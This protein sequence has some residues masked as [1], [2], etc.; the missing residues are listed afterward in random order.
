MRNKASHDITCPYCN[1]S[2]SLNFRTKD[3]NRKMSKEL[4]NYYC[5]SSCALIFLSPLPSDLKQYYSKEYY[6]VPGTLEELANASTEEK[7]KVEIIQQFVSKGRLLEVGPATGGFAYHAK[8]AGYEVE[9]IEMD[10]DC[11]RFLREVVK[12]PTV[13]SEDVIGALKNKE[14]YNVIALWH[15]IEHLPQPWDTLKAIVDYLAPGGILV[16]AAPN[17]NAFQFKV[18][19]KFWA[20]VDAPRH[21]ELIP[22]HLLAQHMEK[23]GLKVVLHTTNDRGGLGWN[24]FGWAY[25]LANFSKRSFIR[26]ALSFMGITAARLLYPI[27]SRNGIGSAYTMVFQKEGVQ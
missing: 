21:L 3:L 23:S 10:P 22:H 11:C 2:A 4:F 16:L 19:K 17:P 20:H 27:E 5:C 15:V 25:S 7:Y 13:Q 8:V 26:K 14:Q 18:L 9:T 1:H 24:R 12:I 6:L